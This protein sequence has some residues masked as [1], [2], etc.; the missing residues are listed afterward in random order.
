MPV[1]CAFA[2]DAPCT[3]F[4]SGISLAIDLGTGLPAAVFVEESWA[5]A[6]SG[7]LSSEMGVPGPAS[8]ADGSL[9]PRIILRERATELKLEVDHRLI[10]AVLGRLAVAATLIADITHRQAPQLPRVLTVTSPTRKI[11]PS[12][13]SF[14]QRQ[15]VPPLVAMEINEASDYIA[16]SPLDAGSIEKVDAEPT[17]HELDYRDGNATSQLDD[18]EDQHSPWPPMPPSPDRLPSASLMDRLAFSPSTSSSNFARSFPSPSVDTQFKHVRFSREAGPLIETARN[19]K[20]RTLAECSEPSPLDEVF[21][22]PLHATSAACNVQHKDRLPYPFS[23]ADIYP[24]VYPHFRLYPARETI[25]SRPKLEMHSR[26]QTDEGTSYP[27]SLSAIY[28]PVY[29]HF[30]LYPSSA[31]MIARRQVRLEGQSGTGPIVD[32]IGYPFSLACIY[33]AVYPHINI[34]P[35]SPPQ[36]VQTYIKMAPTVTA[37]PRRKLSA[38]RLSPLALA[39]Q[40]VIADG[41]MPYSPSENFDKDASTDVA[42]FRRK[43]GGPG[44]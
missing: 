23:L 24:P 15:H 2:Q 10:R 38:A 39:R 5:I 17:R 16:Q 20:M 7:L 43:K 44:C 30:D 6:W 11:R 26:C 31:R 32:R 9:V 41:Q 12:N 19:V 4:R 1:V 34:Y 13:L 33:P 35:G 21:F 37:L 42:A 18:S 8:P 36:A 22:R 28:P 29:P 3:R 14:L 40:G 25:V 27:F